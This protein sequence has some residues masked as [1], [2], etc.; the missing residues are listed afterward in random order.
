MKSHN[1]HSRKNSTSTAAPLVKNPEWW[2]V[3]HPHSKVAG[4][5]T[6]ATNVKTGQ[7]KTFNVRSSGKK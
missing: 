3:T 6:F 2:K 1:E 5:S 7:W 4:S